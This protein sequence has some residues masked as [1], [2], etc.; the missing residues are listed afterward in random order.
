MMYASA[1]TAFSIALLISINASDADAALLGGDVFAEVGTL[2]ADGSLTPSAQPGSDTGSV[3]VTAEAASPGTTWESSADNPLTAFYNNLIQAE[4]GQNT[5]GARAVVVAEPLP[6]SI[7]QTQPVISLRAE[8]S[9][10]Q[11]NQPL[12]FASATGSFGDKI[13]FC[14]NTGRACEPFSSTIGG[15]TFNNFAYTLDVD[16]KF[17]AAV[18]G[19]P[20]GSSALPPFTGF[21]VGVNYAG[22]L[23][24][25]NGNLFGCSESTDMSGNSR[26]PTITGSIADGHLRFSIERLS[27]DQLGSDQFFSFSSTITASPFVQGSEDVSFID[28]I[29]FAVYGPDGNLVNGLSVNSEEGMY[30]A[31]EGGGTPAPASV[32]EPGSGSILLAGLA[33]LG[34]LARNK[35]RSAN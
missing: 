2:S 16:M 35:Q 3:P 14:L 18:N 15:T 1:I 31:V 24:T 7:F 4:N 5:A 21:L 27:A 22:L 25:E 29:S 19:L 8:A 32:P 20:V 10:E 6:F 11:A 9:S 13:G 33:G 12:P 34:L 26:G 30:Y 23:C 28:P 17:T